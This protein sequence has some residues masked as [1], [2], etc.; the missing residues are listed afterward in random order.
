[1][2]TFTSPNGSQN[3][4]SQNA[5]SHNAGSYSGEAAAKARPAPAP[6]WHATP[7]LDLYESPT[8]LLIVLNVPGADPQSIEVQ[9]VG[10]EL[11]VRAE[12][13]ASEGNGEVARGVFERRFDLP[14]EV[15]PSSAA[16]ELRDGVLEIRLQKSASARRVK[17]PVSAN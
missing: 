11:A 14:V 10:N 9:V 17:I 6:S 16:A 5:G 2:S 13:A 1:M 4:A 3:A 7:A 12:Q 8:E 15:D